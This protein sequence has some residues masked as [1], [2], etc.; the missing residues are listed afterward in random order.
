MHVDESKKFDKRNITRNIKDGILTQKEYEAYL[1]KLPDVRGK[2][3]VPE[4]EEMES[5]EYGASSENEKRLAPRGGKKI[6][7]K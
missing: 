7:G 3:F 1:A 4:E 6:R 5:E 2:I